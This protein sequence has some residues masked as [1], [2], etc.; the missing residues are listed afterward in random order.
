[1]LGHRR[2]SHQL[3]DSSAVKRKLVVG[4]AAV[5]QVVR[6]FVPQPLSGKVISM[7]PFY[8]WTS[9]RHFYCCVFLAREVLSF[10]GKLLVWGSLP[11]LGKTENE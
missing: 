2:S 3:I 8:V 10:G 9:K 11:W 4:D 5:F 1:M 6:S 7:K